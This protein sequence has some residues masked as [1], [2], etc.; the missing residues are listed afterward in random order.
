MQMCG[1]C[2]S[3]YDES[4]SAGCPYCREE[5]EDVLIIY[6]DEETGEVKTKNSRA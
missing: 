6:T 1:E 3:V 4:E 5:Q 2:M